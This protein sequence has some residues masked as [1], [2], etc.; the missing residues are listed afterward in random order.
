MISLHFLLFLRTESF[1]EILRTGVL[2]EAVLSPSTK[3]PVNC[4][5]CYYKIYDQIE[6]IDSFWLLYAVFRQPPTGNLP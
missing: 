4:S 5:D 6:Q 2:F 1:Y 3:L